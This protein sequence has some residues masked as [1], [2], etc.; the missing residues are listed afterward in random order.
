MTGASAYCGGLWLAA[1]ACMQVFLKHFLTFVFWGCMSFEGIYQFSLR[2]VQ[3]QDLCEMELEGSGSE[4][5]SKLARAQVCKFLPHLPYLS[6]I[7][8]LSLSISVSYTTFQ[9]NTYNSKLWAGDCFKFDS[10]ERGEKVVLE[11]KK[12]IFCKKHFF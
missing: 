1:L 8:L 2:I 11:R 12:I 10:S 9:Q 3:L 6:S 4:W 5:G 7:S